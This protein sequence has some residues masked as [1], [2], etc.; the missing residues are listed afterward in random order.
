[1]AAVVMYSY[2]KSVLFYAACFWLREAPPPL[3]YYANALPA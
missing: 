1:M 3:F 2:I